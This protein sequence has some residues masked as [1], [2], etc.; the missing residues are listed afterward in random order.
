MSALKIA[1]V[2]KAKAS[3]I[4]L[5]DD[6]PMVRERLAEIIE[7]E[8]DMHVVGE[9]ED[10]HAALDV[11][12][13]SSPD[14]V[15]VDLTLKNSSGLELIRDLRAQYP[16]IAIRVVSMHDESL[17][18]ERVIQAGARGYITKQEATKNILLA[19]RTVLEGQIYLSDKISLKIATKLA[20][21]KAAFPKSMAQKLTDREMAVFEMISQGFGTRQI[22]ERLALNMRTVE[23]YRARIKEKLQLKDADELRRYA[24]RWFQ[25]GS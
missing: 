9:A 4:L 16:G 5:V 20:H 17:H 15:I 24:I 18:A 23:T 14:L 25:S 2:D 12:R 13:L 1:R 6:H 3:R 19:I 21:E 22:A 8:P 10:R 7:R 11:V